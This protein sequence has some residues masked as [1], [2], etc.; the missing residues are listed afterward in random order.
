MTTAQAYAIGFVMDPISSINIKKDSTF[1]MMLEA[2]RRGCSL[3]H[4]LQ[5][6]LWVDDG[7]VFARMNPV[8]VT[9]DQLGL[10]AAIQMMEDEEEIHLHLPY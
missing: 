1:A 3:Y 8:T 7:V 4:I 2:Q 10:D 9:D 5:G 6:D